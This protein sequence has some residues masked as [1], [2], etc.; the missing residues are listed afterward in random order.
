[1]PATQ[2]VIPNALSGAP[3]APESS[4]SSARGIP[5]C[6]YCSSLLRVPTLRP[7]P[8]SCHPEESAS[9]GPEGS[10]F[11]VL[12]SGPL[13]LLHRTARSSRITASSDAA[14]IAANHVLTRGNHSLGTARLRRQKQIMGQFEF[15]KAF[16]KSC[17]KLQ[18]SPLAERAKQL[19]STKPDLAF[20]LLDCCWIGRAES[21]LRSET[22]T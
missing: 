6:L 20:P 10:A 5:P 14:S 12:F 18:S 2:A 1:L 3:S 4:S 7:H 11:S 16:F 21:A 22:L 17:N 8:Q 13:L 19:L 9:G 15:G